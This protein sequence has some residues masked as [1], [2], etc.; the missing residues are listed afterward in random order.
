MARYKIAVAKVGEPLPKFIN[1]SDGT[2]QGEKTCYRVEI[3]GI[4]VF[5]QTPTLPDQCPEQDK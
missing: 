5:L 4:V 3:D 2:V 1:L